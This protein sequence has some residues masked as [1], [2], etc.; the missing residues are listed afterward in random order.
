MCSTKISIPHKWLLAIQDDLTPF[1]ARLLCVACCNTCDSA[2]P[3]HVLLGPRSWSI[4]GSPSGSWS[5]VLW[6]FHLFLRRFLNLSSDFNLF[7]VFSFLAPG[8]FQFF[9]SFSSL[10]FFFKFTNFYKFA[11]ILIR[12]IFLN[13]Q[14]F[15]IH[16]I[17]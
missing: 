13:L 8:F 9:I 12:S 6:S 4:S 7:F 1:F 15:W 14:N 16:D 2:R 17:F 10:S 11:N 3:L 5:M